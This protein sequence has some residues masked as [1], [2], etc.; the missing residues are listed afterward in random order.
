M[1]KKTISIK[2]PIII[3][4]CIFS[5]IFSACTKDNKDEGNVNTEVTTET[6]TDSSSQE[7]NQ[8]IDG[9]Y[10]AAGAY[11]SPAGEEEVEL[12]ITIENG[13]ITASEF[14]A[15]SEHP[16]SKKLQNRFKDGYLEEVEGMNIDEVELDV[17]NGSS[18][19]PKGFN[20]AL[21]KIKSEARA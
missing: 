11:T 12:K 15:N 21:E 10:E 6:E 17:V 19:T 7:T 8:Y 16:T 13:I 1:N 18:L 9:E 2:L 20:D 4:L 14:I 5:L 3:V